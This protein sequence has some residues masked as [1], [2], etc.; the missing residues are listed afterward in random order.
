MLLLRVFLLLSVDDAAELAFGQLRG[1][2]PAAV[3][4]RRELRPDVVVA[5]VAHALELGVT[6]PDELVDGLAE[7]GGDVRDHPRRS[8]LGQAGARRDVAD[9][10]L[11]VGL[12]HG[13]AQSTSILPARLCPIPGRKYVPDRMIGDLTPKTPESMASGRSW[14]VSADGRSR[15]VAM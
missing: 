4:L 8:R 13:R 10:V 1:P 15:K 3:E 12:A 11:R 7:V 5:L 9:Q 2:E 6:S 14:P